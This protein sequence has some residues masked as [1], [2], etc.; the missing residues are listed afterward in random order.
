MGRGVSKGAASHRQRVPGCKIP[1]VNV[2]DLPK[3][4]PHCVTRGVRSFEEVDGDDFMVDLSRTG[5]VI[6]GILRGGDNLS[7]VV[8]GVSTLVS[9][10][11][12]SPRFG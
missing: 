12:K 6:R 8:H 5:A 11:K 7:E 3:S 4:W 2:Q 10:C 9:E 1:A